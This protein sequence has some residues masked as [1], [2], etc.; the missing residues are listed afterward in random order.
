VAGGRQRVGGLG[1]RLPRPLCVHMELV[2][3]RNLHLRLAVSTRAPAQ[4]LGLRT[5]FNGECTSATCT[6]T[7]RLQRAPAQALGLRTIFNGVYIRNLHPPTG[8]LSVP[9]PRR[10]GFAPFST[11]SVHPQP[12]T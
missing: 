4:A 6:P 5:L 3:I 8:R 7:G 1:V 2:Y 11:V 10:W 12:A 9:P